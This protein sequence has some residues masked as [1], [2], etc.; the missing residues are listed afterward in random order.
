[1]R[2]EVHFLSVLLVDSLL[3]SKKLELF[4]DSSVISVLSLSLILVVFSARVAFTSL[5]NSQFKLKEVIV[6]FTYSVVDFKI[7]I[8]FYLFNLLDFQ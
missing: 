7:N 6:K 8:V 4:A 3:L 2:V 5:S 1:M